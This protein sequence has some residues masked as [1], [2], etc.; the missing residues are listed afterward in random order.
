ME[1]M[2][3]RMKELRAE[4]KAAKASARL[5]VKAQAAAAAKVKAHDAD[6]AVYGESD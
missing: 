6:K 5:S 1:A 3:A 2:R 4:R